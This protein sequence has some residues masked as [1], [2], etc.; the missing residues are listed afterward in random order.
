[1]FLLE[2][3]GGIWQLVSETQ[4]VCFISVVLVSSGS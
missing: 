3:F 4:H 2:F 1:M